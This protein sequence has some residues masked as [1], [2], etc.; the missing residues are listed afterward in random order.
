[1]SSVARS[2]ARGVQLEVHAALEAVAGVAVKP[3][4][5]IRPWITAG[6]QNAASRKHVVV[7]SRDARMLA[8]HDAGERRAACARR[9]PS[10]RSG[11]RSSA[12][13]FSSF[14][15]SPA[16]REAHDDVAVELRAIVRVQ[17]L[18]ELEHHVVR[19]VDERAIERMP[20]RSSA[21]LIHA[22]VGAFG[23]CRRSRG[24]RSAGRP[25][26]PRREPRA[27]PCSST[28]TGAT[29]RWRQRRAGRS[30]RLRARCRA[31]TGSRRGSASASA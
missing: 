24:P 29:S 11:S 8:A 14:S 18:A 15:F 22:G 2:T 26:G 17:R 6:F 30:P 23:R 27:S 13:P 10:S 31:S 19:D 16:L 3:S 5:R 28:V 1:M 25:R 9:R 12:S 21:S 7:S 20:L 4:R